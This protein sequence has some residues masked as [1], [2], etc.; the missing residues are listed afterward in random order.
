M[1]NSVRRKKLKSEKVK[2]KK[3]KSLMAEI[4]SKLFKL[5]SQNI[6]ACLLHRI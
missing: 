6:I 4:K 3:V 5:Q 1:C 2:K